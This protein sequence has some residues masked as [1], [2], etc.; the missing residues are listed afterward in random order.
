MP[1]D[2][3]PKK[4]RPNPIAKEATAPKAETQPSKI[5]A[6][7]AK[8]E[9]RKEKDAARIPTHADM[10]KSMRKQTAKKMQVSGSTYNKAQMNKPKSFP[11]LTKK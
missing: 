4:D 6:A 5:K 11:P 7:T 10:V 1:T 3:I 8:T 2:Y 9:E